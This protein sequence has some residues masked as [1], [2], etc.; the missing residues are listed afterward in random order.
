MTMMKIATN[1]HPTSPRKGVIPTPAE[2]IASP[3]SIK[4]G[5]MPARKGFKFNNRGCNP[6]R[7]D[8]NKG[9]HQTRYQDVG[10]P[11]VTA[12]TQ[13]MSFSLQPPPFSLCKLSYIN[14]H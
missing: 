12:K 4:F 5:I 8:H 14:F 13:G 11:V 2:R 6:W 9:K 1:V 7:K 3:S 10:T